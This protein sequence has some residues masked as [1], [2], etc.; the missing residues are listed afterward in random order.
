MFLDHS[1]ITWFNVCSVQLD[2]TVQEKRRSK[3]QLTDYISSFI[4]H[5]PEQNVHNYF[6]LSSFY[7]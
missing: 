6:K 4:G 3:A 2:D 1:V 5:T 7:F